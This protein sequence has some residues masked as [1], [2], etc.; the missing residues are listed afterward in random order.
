MKKTVKS[1][2][3]SDEDRND[4]AHYTQSGKDVIRIDIFVFTI[5]LFCVNLIKCELPITIFNKDPIC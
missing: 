1:N 2:V 4:E 5:I 3:W